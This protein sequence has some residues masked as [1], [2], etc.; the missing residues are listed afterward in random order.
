MTLSIVFLIAIFFVGYFF[1]RQNRYLLRVLM[2][3]KIDSTKQDMLTV[4]VEQLD[5][6]LKYLQNSNYQYLTIQDLINNKT[7][8]KKAVLITFD[9][10]YVNNLELAYPILKKYNAKATI[11][12]PTAY[13]GQGSSWD[14]DAAPVL[15]LLQLQ[16]LDSTVFELGLH[17]HLH[18]NYK[19]LSIQE[20][21]NDIKQNIAFFEE[22]NLSYVPALAYPYGGRPKNKAL[23]IKM[24]DIFT[25]FGVKFAFRIG[26]RL[27]GWP[28]TNLYEIQ[29]LDIRGTDS[30]GAFKRKVRWGR[31]V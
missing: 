11:F 5:E 3:H 27:N 18:Q 4:S 22:N 14:T 6:Q 9:D 25:Q 16:N 1:T 2:Y 24:Y 26:N 28:L 12:I 21:E 23:K 10:G 13:V 7:I 31:L 19:F 15:S 17:S 8:P 30:I 29:R 20:I